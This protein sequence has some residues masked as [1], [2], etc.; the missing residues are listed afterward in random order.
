[1]FCGCTPL[2][3]YS[4]HICPFPWPYGEEQ[5][6][7]LGKGQIMTETEKLKISKL[8]RDGLGYKKIAAVLDLPVNSVKTYLRRHP[9]NEDA[10]AIPDFCEMCGKPIIQIPHR[11]HKR[12]CSDSCRFS[13]WNAHPDKGGKR[14]LNTFTC[15]YCGRTFQSGARDRRYCSRDCYAKARKKAVSENG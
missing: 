1:M 10:T 2:F 8:R 7:L 14:T 12:F 6:G 11:K 13:W 4:P 3:F 15:I 5:P 9:A